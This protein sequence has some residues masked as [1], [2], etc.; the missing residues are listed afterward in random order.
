MFKW[1][2]I[3]MGVLSTAAIIGYYTINHIDND[4][5]IKVPMSVNDV[6]CQLFDCAAELQKQFSTK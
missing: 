6:P 2:F 1:I 5:Q 4:I 3:T